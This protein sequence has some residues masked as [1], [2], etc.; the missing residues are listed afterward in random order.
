MKKG[1][2]RKERQ[3]N[4]QRTSR[5]KS[6]T[7]QDNLLVSQTCS[8]VP[9]NVRA[10]FCRTVK[11]IN[12]SFTISFAILFDLD[13]SLSLSLTSPVS[14]LACTSLNDSGSQLS[15]IRLGTLSVVT[16]YDPGRMTMAGSPPPR[17]N[18]PL[19]LIRAEK[20]CSAAAPPNASKMLTWMTL[21]EAADNQGQR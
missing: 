5:N 10:S 4:R 1:I 18:D 2:R 8:A 3:T 15:W 9:Q 6:S 19:L 14:I 12:H 7:A 11:C 17:F 13:L 21:P 20:P 16:W